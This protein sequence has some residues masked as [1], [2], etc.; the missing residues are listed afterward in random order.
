MKGG[1]GRM[2]VFELNIN[3][4][5]TVTLTEAGIAA[6]YEHY[7]NRNSEVLVKYHHKEKNIYKFQIWELMR[8]FGK[9]MELGA[10][11]YFED[12]RI[13]MEGGI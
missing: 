10:V 4:P 2:S 5:V 1:E 7:I 11:Q 3:D 8:V 12:N 6:L 13:T 9:Y